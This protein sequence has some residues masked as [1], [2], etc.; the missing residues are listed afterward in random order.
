MPR[1]NQPGDAV[2]AAI[3][4][5]LSPGGFIVEEG[6]ARFSNGERATVRIIRPEAIRVES[7]AMSAL[8]RATEHKR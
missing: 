7:G 6:T 2:G 5:L 1:R 8:L 4:K 3:N